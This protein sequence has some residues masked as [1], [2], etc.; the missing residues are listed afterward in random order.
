MYH[1]HKPPQR[2][3]AHIEAIRTERFIPL[4][5]PNN[6]N[7]LLSLKTAIQQ[8]LV[9]VFNHREGQIS[10]KR[11]PTLFFSI[12]GFIKL[13]HLISDI[14]IC[15]VSSALHLYFLHI[16]ATTIRVR[17]FMEKLRVIVTLL[18]PLDPRFLPPR[19]LFQMS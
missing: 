18:K 13:N 7:N 14:K 8:G 4:K 17:N 19:D 9:K 11:S 1:A 2:S 16:I 5:I 15:M 3:P 12:K 6:L 10:N